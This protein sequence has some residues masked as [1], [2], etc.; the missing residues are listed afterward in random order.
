[1]N[2]N[3]RSSGILLHITSLPGP[4]GIGDLG[5]ASFHFVDWLASAGQTIWQLLPTTPIGPGDSPYQSVS[6]FAGS[7]LMVALEPLVAAG[8]L[9]Q[10]PLPG[11]SDARVDF[12][13]VVPWRLAQLRIAFDGF[14]AKASEADHAAINAWLASQASWIDDYS[15]F[16]A[17]ESAHGGA[18]WWDWPADQRSRKKAALTKA[19]TEHAAEIAFWQF[20][21]W[22]F[23]TQLGKVKAYANAKG[24]HIM[25]DLPIFIAHHSADCWA[26]PE[27][28][29]LDKDY[30]PTVVAGVPPDDL[31]PQGQ[32][33]GNPL[34]RWKKMAG[35]GYG[36]WIDRVRR[37]LSQADVFRID[38]FRGF[39]GYY[40]IPASSPTALEG[41]WVE[42][43]GKALFDAIEAAL[44]PVPIVAEDLGLITPDVHALRDSCGFPGMKIL[45]F[46]F[47]ADSNHEFLPHTYPSNC[48]VYPGTHDN[49]TLK[50]WWDHAPQ[51][52]RTFASGYLACG[53]HDV[54]WAMVRA[55]ANS[56]AN[57]A[58]FALQDVLGLPSAARMNTPGTLAGNN[59]TWRFTWDM[60]GPEPGRV[61]G[62]ITAYSGR[63]P[64]GLPV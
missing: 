57:M 64:T 61:L 6:A 7:P 55:C 46:A 13:R 34:Y 10:P 14:Q 45:Q 11:F 35:E 60:V 18:C 59:W 41:Q 28:Y 48:V 30:Q 63:S 22:Q 15:L 16:M 8:W 23:D 9:P 58:L 4:H 53:E 19:R 37:A 17:L 21:Q 38:H 47:G 1:L 39:A 26:R 27:L 33:W 31:G 56:V 32:R 29:F 3:K 2:L 40:E 20:V 52:E 36:W 50:G 5:P 62:L 24:V 42:G 43:P 49:D 54:H 12:A 25:G 51:R 44:G